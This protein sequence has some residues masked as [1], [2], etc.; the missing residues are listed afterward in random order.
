MP[1]LRPLA[2]GL[3]CVDHREFSV[4]GLQIGTRTTVIRLSD[5]TLVVHSP[6]PLSPANFDEIRAIGL[7]S[8]VIAP[9]R[10]HNLYYASACAAF[11]DASH[12]AVPGFSPKQ[13][14]ARLD[15]ILTETL[16]ASLAGDLEAIPLLGAAKLNELLLFHPSTATLLAVDVAFNIRNATGFLHFAMWLNGANDRFCMTRL[17]KSQY[18]D[19]H[20]AS[21]KS[22]DRACDAWPIE[23][24]VVAHGEV[25]ETGGRL[26]LRDAYAFGR[27]AKSYSASQ[28]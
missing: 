7:V 28:M 9:N 6:G 4:G 14:G 1:T 23:R 18:L 20:A 11:P 26:A 27:V 13:P 21:A 3:W 16:P 15:G 24:V 10:M 8:H 12:L 2:D 25:L 22:V 17:G 19:D 5:G